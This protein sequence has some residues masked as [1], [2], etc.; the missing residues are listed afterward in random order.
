MKISK[1]SQKM[2]K[3]IFSSYREEKIM[4]D[5]FLSGRTIFHIY[6]SGD[7]QNDKNDDLAGFHDALLFDVHIYRPQERVKYPVI[8]DRDTI[9]FLFPVSIKVFKDGSTMIVVDRPIHIGVTQ[10]MTVWECSKSGK[11]LEEGVR[12]G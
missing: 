7:T 11:I 4:P 3:D 1:K 8:H 5:K 2:I 9:D 10:A 12:G 6:P